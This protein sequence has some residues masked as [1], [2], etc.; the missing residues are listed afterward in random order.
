MRVEIHRLNHLGLLA[1]LC[2][3]LGIG[4][5]RFDR[6]ASRPGVQQALQCRFDLPDWRLGKKQ[7]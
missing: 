4:R 2:S 1:A 5:T 7:G 3:Y 6:T